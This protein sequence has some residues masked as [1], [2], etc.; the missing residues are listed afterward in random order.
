MA[1]YVRKGIETNSI[2]PYVKATASLYE[3]AAKRTVEAVNKYL[4]M[5]CLEPQGGLYTVIRTGQ[6][7][8]EFTRRILEK[9]GVIVVPGW[10][11]GDTLKLAVR[12]SYGP[13]VHHLD[14]IDLGMKRI[15]EFLA[16]SK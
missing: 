9:T 7:S 3:A 6:E 15:G 11:F 4:K 14:K 1:D 10:G 8:S 5:P 12:V 16:R 13:L 2:K